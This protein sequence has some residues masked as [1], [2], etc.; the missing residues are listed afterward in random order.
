MHRFDAHEVFNGVPPFGNLNLFACDSALREAVGR[1]GAAAAVEGLLA[2]GAQ[3]GREETLDLARLANLHAPVLHNFDRNGRRID[4]IE[5]HPPGT[6]CWNCWSA[7]AR[8]LRPSGRSGRSTA[9]ARAHARRQVLDLQARPRLRR[10]GDRGAGRRTGDRRDGQC[11]LRL[12][13]R[14]TEPGTC[15]FAADEAGARVLAERIVLAVQAG[16]LLRHAPAFVASAFV[17]LRLAREQ[18][19]AYG[20]LPAGTDCAAI[21]ERALQA[22]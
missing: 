3:L 8:M 6:R 2:L 16:L 18:G 1:E 14:P 22:A 13:H 12:L 10:R 7:P 19:G 9:G 20:R 4:E 21:L 5:F 17:A 11:R 15:R